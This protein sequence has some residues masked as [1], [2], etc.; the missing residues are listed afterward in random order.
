MFDTKGSTETF[1]DKERSMGNF[2]NILK[3]SRKR[4]VVC[5]KNVGSMG[6]SM[7]EPRL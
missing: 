3:F 5:V 2:V 1:Q 7:F 4:I 6:V